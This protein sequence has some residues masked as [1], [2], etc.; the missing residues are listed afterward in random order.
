MQAIWSR[1]GQAHRCGC[2]ACFNASGGMIRQS[3]TRSTQRKPTFSEIFTACYTSIMGTAAMLD[4]GRKDRR[5]KD[6]D[7]QI[8]EVSSELANLVEKAKEKAPKKPPAGDVGNRY[9][10]ALQDHVPQNPEVS[11][12]LDALGPSYRWQRTVA[13]KADV[14]RLWKIYELSPSNEVRG[15]NYE[16]LIKKLATEE[17]MPIEHRAPRTPR[18]A[19]AAAVATKALVYRFLDAGESMVGREGMQTAREEVDKLIRKK[20]P[21]WDESELSNEALNTWSRELNKALRSVFDASTPENF[22]HTI[23]S[24][25]H[26]LL[27]SPSSLTIHTY[28]HLI[29]GLDRVG[30]HRLASAVVLSFY[31]GKLEPTQLTLVCILNH[32]RTIKDADNFSGFIARMTGKDQRGVKI[33]RKRH[34]DVAE[35]FSLHG[36]AKT[37]DVAVGSH[38]VVERARF[39]EKIFATIIEGMLAFDRLR[40]AVGA[41]AAS[42]TADLLISSRTTSELLDYC[43]RSLDRTAAAKL[44]EILKSNPALIKRAFFRENDKLYLARRIRSLLDIC[45]LEHSLPNSVAPFLKDPMFSIVSSEE[46]KR[47]VYIAR[48][49][50]T[51][52]Q[53]EWLLKSARDYV[54]RVKTGSASTIRIDSGSPQM[55]RMWR[56]TKLV[57]PVPEGLPEDQP[58]TSFSQEE[59]VDWSAWNRLEEASEAQL[60]QKTMSKSNTLSENQGQLSAWDRLEQAAETK[61]KNT[62]HEN[63]T[64]IDEVFETIEILFLYRAT[65]SPL[66]CGLKRQIREL[67]RAVYDNPEHTGDEME[68]KCIYARPSWVEMPK[69]AQVLDDA[70]EGI[71]T[72]AETNPYW[73]RRVPLDDDD[74][75][76]YDYDGDESD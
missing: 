69:A 9:P 19:K 49:A 21:I 3:A 75:G 65:A 54:Q 71:A 16:A 56:A 57:W 58:G 25:C 36:W 33:R 17:W 2:K 23:Y 73:A 27:V 62:K 20:F 50:H 53:T 48:I 18:Q 45:G 68:V 72:M 60:A 10:G 7:R 42:I 1:A 28:N 39:D 24:V 52:H 15:V 31:Q 32:Y 12:I 74:D 29:A 43:A 46:Q 64:T 6:L 70:Q 59:E 14:D 8:E 47:V 38:Y 55:Y 67:A 37:K 40:A 4:A 61:P 22:Q 13:T 44:L 30:M 66:V 26:N 63:K 11:K 34:D 35:F 76:D 41:F 5:R 51:V